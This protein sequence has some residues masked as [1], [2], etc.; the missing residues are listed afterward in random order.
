MSKKIEKDKKIEKKEKQDKRVGC[1]IC[2]NKDS[3]RV[4]GRCATCI[5]CGWSKC[6]L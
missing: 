2:G 4:A 1:P 6:S 5:N 3:I